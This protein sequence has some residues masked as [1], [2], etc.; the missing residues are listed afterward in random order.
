MP[1]AAKLPAG[2]RSLN[3]PD[4]VQGDEHEYGRKQVPPN[5][6]R[7]GRI[8]EDYHETREGKDYTKRNIGQ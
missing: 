4:N 6:A 5:S 8:G 7:S 2:A 3:K 1:I